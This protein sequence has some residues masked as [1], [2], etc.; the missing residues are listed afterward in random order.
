MKVF[1]TSSVKIA[2][3]SI[4]AVVTSCTMVLVP[5]ATCSEARPAMSG[6]DCAVPTAGSG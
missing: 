3:P 4:R 1:F 6:V 2:M 5:T